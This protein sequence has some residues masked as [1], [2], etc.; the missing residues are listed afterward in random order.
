MKNSGVPIVSE[1]VPFVVVCLIATIAFA[2]S[3]IWEAS[4]PAG[5]ITAY[6]VYFFRNPERLPPVGSSMIAAPADGKVI[7]V[8]KAKETRFLNKEMK[9]ISIFMNLFN[10]HVN[11][12]P[13]DGTIRDMHYQKGRF[14]AANEDRASEEN[15]HNSMLIETTRGEQVVL[16][17]VAGLVARR[18]VCYPAIGAFLL[19]GQR[20]GLIRFGSRVDIYLPLSAEA[21]VKEGDKVLGGE[22]IIARLE[23][24]VP[25]KDST[26][27]S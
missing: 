10:V 4:L 27:A 17:Q 1:G 26:D 25:E 18:I 16:V 15:E 13:L 9:K 3:G 11:R 8:G 23:N 24:I 12:V 19:K 20:M 14:M 5:L 21:M 2:V 22:S 6:V 7:V